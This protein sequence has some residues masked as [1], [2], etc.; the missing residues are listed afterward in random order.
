MDI[1]WTDMLNK[2]HIKLILGARTCIF[3][4]FL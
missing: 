1:K 4:G 3:N 2:K